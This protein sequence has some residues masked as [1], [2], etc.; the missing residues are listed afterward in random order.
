HRQFDI[1]TQ[2][3]KGICTLKLAIECK[4][5]KPSFPLLVSRMPRRAE[6][7][8][9]EVLLSSA[10][11]YREFLLKN[12]ATSADHQQVKSLFQPREFVGKATVQIGRSSSG[13]FVTN[14]AEVFE[15]WSQAIGSAFDLIATSATDHQV[16]GSASAATVVF[17]I[18]VV[19]DQT[20]WVADYSTESEM[21]G[22]A[23]LVSE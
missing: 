4:N 7:S 10:A 22:N 20:L 2:L 18:L 6:E 17:P 13:D 8:Y 1:R 23:R 5:L 19:T 12:V 3:T 21:L 15:K 9:H 11:R 14:D 16:I